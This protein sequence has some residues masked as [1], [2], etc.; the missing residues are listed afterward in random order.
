MLVAITL[1][2]LTVGQTRLRRRSD[3]QVVTAPPVGEPVA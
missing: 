3:A 2:Q 1:V